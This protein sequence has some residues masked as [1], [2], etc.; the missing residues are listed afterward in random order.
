MDAMS[1]YTDPISGQEQPTR[2]RLFV[3]EKLDQFENLDS[4]WTSCRQIAGQLDVPAR[5][6]HHWVRG[7]RATVQNSSWPP[8]VAQFLES[9]DGLCFL[10]ELLTAAH[11]VFVQANDCGIRSLCWFLELSRLDEFVAASYGTQRAVAEEMESLLITFGQQED[12]RLAAHMPPRDISLCEDETFHPQI[13]LVAIEPVS[14]FILVEQYQP[15]RDADTWN[16]CL[17]ER[18]AA[19]PVNVCQ[20][21]SDQAK[22]LIAHT[23]I[24]L[25]A[26]HSPDLFHVQYDTVRATSL[27]LM[28]QTR[29]AEQELE[30]AQ[31]KTGDLRQQREACHQQCPQTS[32]GQV[33]Q[34]Q[35]EQAE[36][37]QTVASRRV[38]ECRDRQ[39]RATTA[40]QGLGRDYHPFDLDGGQPLTADQ[41]AQRLAGHFDALDQIAA[42]A[43]LST[44][45]REKLAKARRVLNGLQATVAFF[46]TMIAVRF[47]SWKLN[48]PT[49]Q[50]LREQLI[51]GFY[52][53]R[54]AE[55]A[56]TSDER[57]RL[58][59]LSE[60]ILARA[61]SPDGLWETL[62]ADV[63]AELERKAQDC[64]DLFQRSSSCVEGRNGHLSLKHHALHQLTSRKLRALTVLHN[65]A[66]RRKDGSTAAERFYGTAPH[67]L[68]AWLLEHISLPARP[69]ARR[70]AA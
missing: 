51:P 25:G 12:E 50:W 58:R 20:V 19:L 7:K 21:T 44:H 40:R 43:S 54:V 45:A 22:A 17:D 28:G 8:P 64:A 30:T 9:P 31:Q 69:R 1:D 11:L 16:R 56:A 67:N 70:R 63:Q 41:V 46:W 38:V 37:D 14:N 52:L 26:H 48:A 68:F 65:Y 42:D 35:L 60:E 36:A 6:L 23:E 53:R 29:R 39:Q 15:Q 13:C 61:R 5:T 10:H 62:S 34:Q 33:L 32:H 57:R 18:L 4:P 47:E 2:S 59:E 55:K 66:V 27:A 49:Q 3:A 24:H